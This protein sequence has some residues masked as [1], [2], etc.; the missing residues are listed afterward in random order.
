MTK[1]IYTQAQQLEQLQADPMKP[2]RRAMKV[3]YALGILSGIAA[4][5]LTQF[6]I[7]LT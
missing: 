7:S 4:T 5:Y 2:I 1:A 6:L 3:I